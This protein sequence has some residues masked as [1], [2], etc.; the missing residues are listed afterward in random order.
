MNNKNNTILTQELINNL[1]DHH[2]K[3]RE[4]C[5]YMFAW[6]DYPQKILEYTEKHNLT[7]IHIT[8]K[9]T[10]ESIEK[11]L[12]FIL[13]IR[14]KAYVEKHR[15]GYLAAMKAAGLIAEGFDENY[16]YQNMAKELKKE[17]E[18]NE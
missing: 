16:Y 5:N 2:K 12:E 15:P 18:K 3:I 13:S 11:N 9:C 8:S 4:H 6:Q 10:L 7:E 17:L 14:N 1:E